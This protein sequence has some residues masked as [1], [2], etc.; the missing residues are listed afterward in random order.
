M[1]TAIV[2]THVH[3]WDPGRLDY[4][5]LAGVPALN[6]PR[7]AETLLASLPEPVDAVFVEA[8]AI[9]GDAAAE[10]EWVREQARR[11]PWIRGAVADVPLEDPVLARAEIRRH[12]TDP[13]V[14]GVRRN[15]QDEAPGFTAEA[16][17][18][19]GVRALGDAALPFDA[20][21]REHQLPELVELCAACPQTTIVLNHLGKPG[22]AHRSAAAGWREALARLAR[23]DN[24]VCK[25]SGLAT[26]LPP[27]T[28]PAQT[29][30]LLREALD[31]F[32]PERCMYGSDWPV[33]TLATG[34][35][36]WLDLVRE[37]LT[38]YS[39][40]DIDSVLGANAARIYRLE[41]VSPSPAPPRKESD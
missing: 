23:R 3:F 24:A 38:T 8:G 7:T 11:H 21:V 41:P 37:A 32:G 29:I 31:T 30:D 17:F 15:V 26:E 10:I 35:R 12:A 19:A 36:A 2:D 14:V 34:Y 13:F 39:S 33:M 27:G 16:D 9:P 40:D 6:Q 20:C 22:S 4:P 25:L 18:R 28:A 1:T 5:W